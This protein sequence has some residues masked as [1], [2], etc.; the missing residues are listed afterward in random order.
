MQKIEGAAR[1]TASIDAK[2]DTA[3]TK[4]GFNMRIRHPCQRRN[5]VNFECAGPELRYFLA[6]HKNFMHKA[7]HS[8]YTGIELLSSQ[9]ID[10]TRP[11]IEAIFKGNKNYGFSDDSEEDEPISGKKV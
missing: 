7:A 6:N 1:P 5:T 11:L 8:G 9:A 10:D 3:T 4:S 2:N